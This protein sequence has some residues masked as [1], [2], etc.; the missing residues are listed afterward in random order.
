MPEEMMPKEISA[1]MDIAEKETAKKKMKSCFNRIGWG[2]TTTMLIW[3]A[4]LYSITIGVFVVDYFVPNLG[5]ADLYDRFLL[6]INELTLAIAIVVGSFVIG[7]AP[8]AEAHGEKISL[9][10][11]LRILCICFAVSYIGNIIGTF[12]L[13]YWTMF[14]GNEVGGDLEAILGMTN[15]IM[16][17]L[18]VGVLAPILEE[19][20]FRKLLIDRMRKYGEVVSI[21][22]S[23]GLFALF[24]QNFAQFLYTF[25]AGIMLG[26]L[27]YRTGSYWR[28]T[29]L[30]AI[31]N[32][33]GGVLPTLLLPDILAFGE[34]WA[35]LESTMTNVQTYD[36]IYALIYPIIEKYLI[37]LLIYGAYLLILGA[38]NITGV[39]FLV[40]GCRKYRAEKPSLKLTAPETFGAIFKNPGM[41]C[42]LILLGALTVLSLFSV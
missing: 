21:L 13:S 10:S 27:Y 19:F 41:I 39:V 22:V 11:F 20:V 16:M 2:I 31:F 25:A 9:G 26:Y 32:I 1:E 12:F 17:F 29:L 5:F 33:I 15:P 3:L 14:T 7:T 24:H 36:E 18:S 6:I 37:P 8:K 28:V 30:H 34:E 42:T 38:V 40:I 35:L 4:L 23:A